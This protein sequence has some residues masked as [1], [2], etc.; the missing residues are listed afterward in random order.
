MVRYLPTGSE[1][2]PTGDTLHD[3]SRKTMQEEGNIGNARGWKKSKEGTRKNKYI[4]LQL[5]KN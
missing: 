1:S 3:G 4:V 2:H 5:T